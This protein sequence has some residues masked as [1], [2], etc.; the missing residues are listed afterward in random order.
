MALARAMAKGQII[1]V[2]YPSALL[3]HPWK[4]VETSLFF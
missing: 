2:G 3:T 1:V 4:V